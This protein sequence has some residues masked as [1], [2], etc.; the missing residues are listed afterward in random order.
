MKHI[1]SC[2]V[3]LLC[4]IVAFG[5]NPIV[6]PGVFIADPSAHVW[7]DGKLYVYGSRDESS[8]YWCSWSYR[9]LSTDDLKSWQLSGE[10]FSNKSKG[11]EGPLMDSSLYAPD[12][13]YR[14]GMYYLYYSM[15]AFQNP[16]GV[17]VSSSPLGPFVNKKPIYLKGFNQ[18][19]PCVFI[20]DDGQAYYIWGQ[21]NAKVAKLKPNMMELDT[22]TI[23]ENIVTQKE[24]YFHE[25]GY[26]IKHNGLYYFI[27]ADVS[28]SGRPTCLG[29]ATG[30]SPFGPFTYRGVIIDN[31][32]SDPVVWNNHGSLVQFK[33]KW[34]VFYHR[35]TNG[36]V[37]LRKA[38]LEPITFRAD[39]FIPEVE[40]TSQGAAGP[41]NPFSETDAA[42]ACLV[43][44]S[45]RIKTISADNEVLGEI[46]SADKAAYKYF[47]F[48]E[49][50]D[51]IMIR[52]KP[53]ARPCQ[54]YLT[55]DDSWSAP[56]GTVSVPAK[57]AEEWLS[58]KTA[59][60]APKGV[61][62]L[63]LRF[64]DTAATNEFG[65]PTG[66]TYEP[67]RELLQVD[68]FQLFRSERARR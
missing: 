28:R 34:Y 35:A 27:Y 11:E 55:V 22:T 41:L 38:C 54:I 8:K 31:N 20:D 60:K 32:N 49:G 58:L 57:G 30:K 33:G 7:K 50:A 67:C 64:V 37:T 2:L 40:M 13:Q 42:K 6:P 68:A 17:A 9:V 26:M 15:A 66:E 62:A 43:M 1:F 48:K 44:G 10:S 23:R 29:Y 3:L 24:H 51:S 59:V 18:I 63:W 36:S 16:E 12:V 46:N 5:Q 45:I 52:V 4:D 47:D 53:G 65:M 56:I 61:H 39:G 21:F 25:G 19:D 14:N